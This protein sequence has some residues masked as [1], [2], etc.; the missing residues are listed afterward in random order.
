MTLEPPSGTNSR[1]H[2]TSEPLFWADQAAQEIATARTQY[3]AATGIT[4]SGDIHI[5]NMREV[6]TADVVVRALK[7]LG[8]DVTFVYIADTYDPLRRVY[9]FLDANVFEKHVGAPLSDIPCPC[10]SHTSYAEHFLEPFLASLETLDI[11]VKVLHADQLYKTGRY[12]K[13]I[14]RALQNKD[15]IRQILKEETGKETPEDWS[16]FNPICNVCRR[17]IDAKVTGFDAEKEVVH[18]RCSCGDEGD[19]PM[20]GGGKLTWRVDWAARWEIV[21][22]TIEPFGKDH[23]SKGGSYDTGV[24]F[25]REIFE[26]EPPFPVV[27]EWISLRGGGDMSSSKGNVLSIHEMLNVIPPDV[28]KYSVIKARPNRR[29]TFDPGL[30]LLTLMDEF[31]DPTSK[32]RLPRAVELAQVSG[33]P[34]LGIPFRHIVSLIQTAQGNL[35]EITKILKREGYAISDPKTLEG[36]VEY[37]QKWLDKFGP[38]DLKFTV[39]EKMPEMARDLSASQKKALGL[40]SGRLEEGLTAEKIHLL[41]YGLKDELGLSPKELFQAIYKSILGKERGP[42]AGFFLASLD[43]EFVKKRFDEVAGAST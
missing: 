25:S 39:Q 22:T 26:Y 16:P 36:R 37:A 27:Y 12:T 11:P 6:V 40:L 23:A 10:G 38:E 42:R 15:R 34:P 32:A 21:G 19:A 43:T 33:T 30:P 29:I 7:A 28:L 24:R 9:P 18:Y 14:I 31:D 13:N 41:I 35:A 5:G 8:K 2:M 3:V 1:S 17:M 4:P 20:A